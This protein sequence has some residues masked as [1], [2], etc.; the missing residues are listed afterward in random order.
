MKL[1]IKILLII[2][3]LISANVVFASSSDSEKLDKALA[4]QH[5]GDS[6]KRDQYRHPKET[7]EFFQVQSNHHVVEIWPGGGGWYTRVLAPYLRDEGKL[8]A[9]Q[10]S[11]DTESAYRQRSMK[12][13]N[14]KLAKNP[15]VFDKVSVT[16]FNPPDKF[17]MAPEG[18]VDRVLTFRSLHN[19]LGAGD[20]AVLEMFKAFHKVL[21][22]G[23]KL[24]VVDHR[25]PED[26]D[27]SKE[28]RSGYVKQSYAIKMAEAA[29]FKLEASSE[30]NANPKDTADHP[31]GVWTLL[32]TLTLKDENRD[33]YLSI[34][35]SDRMTL[36]F[37]KPE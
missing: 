12:S 18:T 6:A 20:E 1:Y 22:P 19:W 23:G 30:I 15:E 4:G 33:K 9:A 36:L 16:V 8:Y 35:E 25:L 26:R 24:G 27:Q 10:Y 32:P 21:K 29:G 11:P 7:L 13:F 37:V 14:E 5:R 31:K 17:D 28:M 2:S 34:G 3:T